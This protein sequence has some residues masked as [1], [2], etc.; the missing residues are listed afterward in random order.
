MHK[1]T[2]L[3]NQLLSDWGYWSSGRGDKGIIRRETGQHGPN[4]IA[5]ACKAPGDS[6]PVLFD[7]ITLE[8]VDRLIKSDRLTER[9]RAIAILH[10][11]IKPESDIAWKVRRYNRDNA[12][13]IVTTDQYKHALK[14]V[15]K[16]VAEDRLIADLAA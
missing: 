6:Q 1:I 12:P 3:V 4:A 5:R 2:R 7:D 15:R 14:K 13:Q 8:R 9:E 10:W 16:M 11:R